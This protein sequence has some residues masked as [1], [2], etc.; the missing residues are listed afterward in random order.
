MKVELENKLDDLLGRY[1]D[2]AYREGLLTA[3]LTSN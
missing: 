2:L 3:H 1:W